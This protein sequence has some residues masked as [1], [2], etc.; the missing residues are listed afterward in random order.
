MLNSSYMTD[1]G[2]GKHEPASGQLSIGNLMSKPLKK[3]I[4]IYKGQHYPQYR[5]LIFWF[6][7]YDQSLAGS[8][9]RSFDSLLEADVFLLKA[10]DIELAVIN[11]D[12]TTKY[13]DWNPK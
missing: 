2:T 4:K 10:H 12:T 3:R 8:Y 13:L 9:A 7:Y 11:T 6:N 1:T 5:K